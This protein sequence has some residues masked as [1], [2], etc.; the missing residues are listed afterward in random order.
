LDLRSG[1][2]TQLSALGVVRVG[3]VGGCT[4]ETADL[5]S[6]RRDATTGRFAGMIWRE[7]DA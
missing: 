7:A 6:Y 5:F 1:L 4:A 2:E 3:R